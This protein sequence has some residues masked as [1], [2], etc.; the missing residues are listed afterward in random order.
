M[1]CFG[2]FT[3][4]AGLLTFTGTAGAPTL[5]PYGSAA[6]WDGGV[7]GT[8]AD[9]A[10]I[11]GRFTINDG[12]TTYALNKLTGNDASGSFVQNG[13]LTVMTNATLNTG[14]WRPLAFFSLALRPMAQA[15]REG[16][17]RKAEPS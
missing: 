1:L 14:F 9:D 12:V 8:V 5:D 2:T 11:T 3:A 10:T 13:K 16:S 7:V 17:G 4:N 6:E 15:R